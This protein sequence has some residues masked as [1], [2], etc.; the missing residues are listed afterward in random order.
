LP[1]AWLQIGNNFSFLSDPTGQECHHITPI[2]K[3]V[4]A[5]RQENIWLAQETNMR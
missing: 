1:D 4:E 3:K 2:V 5:L